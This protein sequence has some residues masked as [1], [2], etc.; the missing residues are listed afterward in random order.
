MRRKCGWILFQLFAPVIFAGL[1]SS[2]S[3]MAQTVPDSLR[4]GTVM[5][6]KAKA[7]ATLLVAFE[8]NYSPPD[9]S[10]VRSWENDFHPVNPPLPDTLL[11]D[12]VRTGPARGKQMYY[13]P[14]GGRS[15]DIRRYFASMNYCFAPGDSVR[16]DSAF[17]EFRIA[18]DGKAKMIPHPWPKASE[19]CRDF[20]KQVYA[21]CAK[22]SWWVPATELRQGGRV[23]IP[24]ASTVTIMIYAFDTRSPFTEVYIQQN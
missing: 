6:A 17:V 23:A 16:I 9:S 5:V 8:Y 7:R 12:S 11:C 21:A 3:L 22:L 14:D 4:P 20:E 15:F 1:V 24:V 19:S 2:C 13:D 18:S 10:L